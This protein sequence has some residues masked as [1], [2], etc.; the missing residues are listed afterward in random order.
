MR[1]AYCWPQSAIAGE[2]V[3][4]CF[5]PD[6]GRVSVE[7][8]RQGLESITVLSK[9]DLDSPRQVM[10][11]DISVIGADWVPCL[12]FQI[13][14]EWSSGFYLV[15]VTD[16]DNR[17]SEAFFVVR[18]Q[19]QQDA[20]LV[21]STSTWAAYNH[22]GGP[23]FYMGSPK[24]SL[25]R[26]LP[27]G[28]LRKEDPMT[29]RIGQFM[30]W[31]EET[32][33]ELNQQRYSPWCMAA[34]WANQEILF[35]QWAEAQGIKL[36]YAISE[37]LD[38][39]PDLLAGVSLYLSV[40]HDE[41]W[42]LA[43]RDQ[44]E[45]FIEAGGNAAFFS[46]NTSF[47]QA[48][49]END[50]KTLISY[51]TN[52]EADPH[53]DSHGA[54]EL[55]TMWSDPLVGRPESEMTGVSFTYGG[56]AHMN[57]APK[58]SGGYQVWDPDHW[59]FDSLEV[60]V[61]AGVG[62]EDITVAYECDG[63]PVEVVDGIPRAIKSKVP[64]GFKLLATAPA[65]LWETREAPPMPDGYIGELNWVAR[66]LGGEDTEAVRAQYSEGHA[67]M[68]NFSKGEGEVFTTGCTDWAY[69][70]KQP[71]V[72]QITRNVIDRFLTKKDQTRK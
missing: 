8:A 38:R 19:R 53:Y 3:T 20:M 42:S 9:S 65:H 1:G 67:V 17:V 62:E 6:P 46:G 22:W 51:K 23:S 57:N 11:E 41:Y 36:S 49:F 55:S 70:L 47:W 21:L 66:R 13:K 50:R 33:E 15:S 2:T 72:S 27:K 48:R 29:H 60:S 63:C 58:G 26:P 25:C 40:G 28:F 39:D 64:D 4:L 12:E 37:D 18:G 44:V 56:Y 68:G 54:P 31:D 43:M 45:S 32:Q 24:S 52:L 59:A 34:G 35:V 71:D 10:P 5:G 30:N 16:E 14:E 69:G 7:V 61:G